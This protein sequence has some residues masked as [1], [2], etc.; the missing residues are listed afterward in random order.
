M[1]MRN[2]VHINTSFDRQVFIIPTI[3]VIASKHYKFRIAFAWLGF[4]ISIGFVR[5]GQTNE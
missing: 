4:L 3:G 5:K 2:R 1:S